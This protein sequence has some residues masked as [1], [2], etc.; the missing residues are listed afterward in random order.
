M[1]ILHTCAQIR[2]KHLINSGITENSLFYDFSIYLKI[3]EGKVFLLWK[4]GQVP[5][6]SAKK[7][8]RTLYGYKK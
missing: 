8:W 5:V 6:Q 7:L 1:F 4:R 3:R 2:C